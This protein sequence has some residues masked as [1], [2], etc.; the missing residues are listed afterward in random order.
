MPRQAARQSWESLDKDH[1]ICYPFMPVYDGLVSAIF[2][3]KG[4]SN[5]SRTEAPQQMPAGRMIHQTVQRNE[6]TKEAIPN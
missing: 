6:R 5:R 2:G 1:M 3:I 4:L